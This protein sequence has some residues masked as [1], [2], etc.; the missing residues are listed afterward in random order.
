MKFTLSWLKTYLKTDASLQEI[1]DALTQLGLVVDK[2]EDKSEVLKSFKIVHVIE[3]TQHPNA[4][5]LKVCRVDTGEG[6]VQ[7]VCGGANARTGIKAVL[8]RPGDAIPSNGMVM[9]VGEIRGVQSYGMLCSGEELM[10]ESSSE[11]IIEAPENAPIGAV[12]AE[13]MNLNDPLI[14]IEITPN[15]GDCL[16]VYGVARDLAATGIGELIV[17]TPPS[18]CI[19]QSSPIQVILEDKD[20][21]PFFGTRYISG[22]NN[23]GTSPEWLLKR[24]TSINAK[25]ISPL[26]DV[27][28]F[29]TFD[30]GRPLHVFDA[31]KIKGPLRVGLSKGG[32]IFEGLDGN[33]YTLDQGMVVI[34]DDS[35]VISLGGIM[36]GMS[37]SVDENTKNVLLE[38]AYFNPASIAMAGRKLGI[39]TDARYRFER[40]VD[41]A[42]VIPGLDRATEIILEICGGSA[43]QLNITGNNPRSPQPIHFNPERTYTLGGLKMD[44]SESFKILENLGYKVKENDVTPPTW[45]FD[46]ERE[47][48]LVED[49]LRVQGYESIPSVPFSSERLHFPLTAKQ[50]RALESRALLASRGLTEL[51]TWSFISEPMAKL[52]GGG[53]A[54]L[55]LINPISEDM[56]VMRPSILPNLLEAASKNTTRGQSQ[57]AFFEVGP[58]YRDATEKGQD[59]VS[60]GLRYGALAPSNWAQRSQNVDAFTA[61]ADV[62]AI[63]KSMSVNTL[64]LQCTRET[65]S[66]YHPGRSG[67]LKQ[68]TNVLA[69]FG[70]VHPKILKEFDLKGP[71]VAFEIFMDKV[72]QPKS[73]KKAK[74]ELS[75]YQMVE[76]DFAFIIDQETAADTL[77]QLAQKADPNLVRDVVIFDYFADPKLGTGKVSLGLRIKLQAMDRTLTDDEI[78]VISNRLIDSIQT[79]AGGTLRQ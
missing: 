13:Y 41:P 39:H 73:K 9:K 66:W 28:N 22:V 48:D 71:V 72:P 44:A 74:L 24:L 42:T 10:L 25:V 69:Y 65:P 55:V 16:G 12:Y 37:T 50:A 36:G 54:S 56:K 61:K 29:L 34:S 46:V 17:P 33:S 38:A 58:Q 60:A 30:Q 78:N 75:P 57:G 26:V 7:V 63:L 68:G 51:V 79:K 5:R 20:S 14:E 23:Q 62:L 3:A 76:R 21:C 49:I 53:D 15:R 6:E 40:N 64:N 32:E 8:A 11:G 4:D 2:V 1:C 45:R 47:A 77:R 19:N 67:A 27:T 31:D 70:E 18:V 59:L 52:F 43:T 35:G